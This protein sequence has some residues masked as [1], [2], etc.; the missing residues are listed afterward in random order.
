LFAKATKSVGDAGAELSTGAYYQISWMA[1]A[2]IV[3]VILLVVSRLDT[4][5]FRLPMI[6]LF[7]YAGLGV[8]TAS[9]SP[10]PLMSIYKASQLLLELMLFVIAGSYLL[11]YKKPALLIDLTTF[12]LAFV[13]LSAAL[14]GVFLPDLAYNVIWG[15]G[16]FGRTLM[17]V[18]PQ[19]FS[20]ELGLLAAMLIIISLRRGSEPGYGFNQRFFWLS[21][22]L[23]AMM[24]LFA[25]QARTSLA[26][27]TI[28][29]LIM[30]VLNPRLRWL[31]VLLMVAALVGGAVYL[32]NG[33][34]L[35]LEDKIT[36]YLRRGQTDQQLQTMSGRTE[37]WRAGWRMFCDS[38][39]LGHGFQTGV[40]FGGE[41]F[42]IA[43]GLNMHNGHYQVLADSGL[44]GYFA[45]LLFIVPMC[46][47]AFKYL[48]KNH[49][50]LRNETDRQHLEAWLVM[51]IVLFRT[52]LGQ[53]LVTHQFSTMLYWAM[54]LYVIIFYM[55]AVQDD[56]EN[57]TRFGTISCGY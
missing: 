22:S 9:F 35:G 42:G 25:A 20:N 33:G 32:V 50:P 29:L 6:M 54:Y 52:F 2:A 12:L 18:F 16:T 15:G 11:K 7:V 48:I 49:M 34:N 5:I 24:V 53:V 27:V 43:R 37:L 19:V 1:F 46:W 57:Q 51:F 44:F 4:R 8:A 38:P 30:S 56:I 47:T 28:A 10:A 14:G 3:L 23:L 31:G 45:W 36:T 21:L 17:C 39:F 41:K 40:R 26:A 13:I 55:T